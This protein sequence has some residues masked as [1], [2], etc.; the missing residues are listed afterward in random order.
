M[1]ALPEKMGF[2]ISQQQERL[3]RLSREGRAVLRPIRASIR[4]DGFL[5]TERIGPAVAGLVSRHEILR[6]GF[7]MLPGMVLP[8]Q[9][10]GDVEPGAKVWAARSETAAFAAELVAHAPGRHALELRLSPLCA[11]SISLTTLFDELAV[12]YEGGVEVLDGEPL[13]YADYA[14]WQHEVLAADGGEGRRYWFGQGTSDAPSLRLSLEND[15]ENS[16]EVKAVEQYSCSALTPLAPETAAALQEFLSSRQVKAESVLLAAWA[17]LLHH[18]LGAAAFTIGFLCDARAAEIAGAIGPYLRFLPFPVTLGKGETF[19]DLTMR[20]QARM[21]SHREWQ[22]VYPG[23]AHRWEFGFGCSEAAPTRRAGSVTLSL[24]ADHSPP[25]PCRLHLH[26]LIRDCEVLLAFHYDGERLGP[27]AVDCMSGQLLSLLTEAMRDP[28]TAWERLSLLGS[29]EH[30][31]LATCHGG[32]T[33]APDVNAL[34]KLFEAQ[35]L[36][37]PGAAALRHAGVVITYGEL[38]QRSNALARRLIEAGLKAEDRVGLLLPSPLCMV[39]AILAVLKAGGAYVPLD[40]AQPGERTSYVLTDAAARLVVSECGS[41]AAL[42]GFDGTVLSHG[43]QDEAGLSENAA[44]WP[45]PPIQPEQLAYLIYTSGSTGQPKGVAISHG[46]ALRSTLARHRVYHEAV[47]GFLLLSSFSFDSSVAGLFW[48]L[49]QGGCLCLP[50]EAELQ[51]PDALA[52]LIERHT[53]SHVLCLPSVWAVLLE[54][55]AAR[56]RSLRVAI[57]AGE[58]CPPGLGSRHFGSLPDTRL[59]NEYGPTEGAVWSTVQEIEPRGGALRVPIGRPIE[60]VRIH[61]L[62]PAGIEVPRGITGEI[63]IGGGG[64][65]R[66]Y[67]RRPALTGATFVPDF[68]SG[69]GSRLYRSGDLGRWRLD[70]MIDF[71]GRADHQIKVRGYRI[72]LGE[73]EFRIRALPGVRDCAVVAREDEPG[74]KRLTAYLVHFNWPDRQGTQGHGTGLEQVRNALKSSLPDYMIP[75][76]WVVLDELPRNANG[77]LDRSRLPVPDRTGRRRAFVAPRGSVETVL[78]EIWE[79]LLSIRPVGIEDNFFELGGDSILSIQMVGRARQRGIVVTARQMIENQTIAQ[80]ATVAAQLHAANTPDHAPSLASAGEIPLT[81]IQCWFFELGY[82]RPELWTHALLLALREPLPPDVLAEAAAALLR[83]HDALRS[84]FHHD[85][86]VW[87]QTILPAAAEGAVVRVVLPELPEAERHAEIE[88]RAMS[89]MAIGID[90]GR[91][92][93]VIHFEGSAGKPGHLLVVLH[94]LVADGISWRLLIEDLDLSCRQIRQGSDIAL[95]MRS[96]SFAEWS[97]LLKGRVAGSVLVEQAEWWREQLRQA[98][99]PLRPDNTAG[100]RREATSAA[101]TR[102]FDA[103]ET[104]ALLQRAAPAFRAS[105][106]DLLLTALAL[107][108]VRHSG[109]ENGREGKTVLIDLD[110]HGRE[111]FDSELD[112]SRTIGWFTS[113][114]PYLLTVDPAQPLRTSLKCVKEQ[115]RRVPERGLGYGIMRYLAPEGNAASL[116]DGPPSEIIFNYMGQLDPSFGPDSLFSMADEEI[117][118]GRD[119]NWERPYELAVNAD[120]LAGRLRVVWDYGAQR[121][122]RQTIESLA[123]DF[124]ETLRRL[125][126]AC[127]A[128]GVGGYTPSDFPLAALGQEQLDTLL[129]ATADIE[130]VYPITPLQEGM[131]FHSLYAPQSGVYVEHLSCI[132]KGHLDLSAFEAAW[133]QVLRSCPVLRTRFV[134]E[135]L[136]RPLQVVHSAVA[137]P[138]GVQDWRSFPPDEQERRWAEYLEVDWRQGFD[139][140]TAPLMRLALL[141]R[142]EDSWYF[143]WSHH[144]IL[145]DGWSGPL[146]LQQA[147]D[148]YR[149]LSAGDPPPRF[150]RR[151]FR[152][153]IAFL[154]RQERAAPEAFFRRFLAGFGE[155][156]PLPLDCLPARSMAGRGKNGP[157][158]FEKSLA[159]SEEATAALETAARRFKVTINT[160]LQ[161]AFSLL[162]ARYSGRR[163]VLFGISV[164]GR[165]AELPGIEEMVGLFI[166]AMPLRVA[167]PPEAAIGE[168]LRQLLAINAEL[169]QYEWTPLVEIQ[170]WSE[171]PR[172][173]ALFE[174]LFAFENYPVD[175]ALREQQ[176]PLVPGGVRFTEQTHYPLTVVA[177]PGPTLII[178]FNADRSYF[179]EG[180]VAGLV[181]YFANLLAGI[182]AAPEGR[183][184]DLCLLAPGEQRRLIA[185]WYGEGTV[186]AD[187]GSLAALFEAQVTRTPDAAALTCEGVSLSYGV[188]NVRANRLA[189]H[190]RR[191]G[192]RPETRVGLCLDRSLDLFVAILAVVKAGGAYVPLDPAHPKERLAWLIGDAGIAVLL[193]AEAMLGSL[194]DGVAASGPPILCLDRDAAGWAEEAAENLSGPSHPDQ[195]A[196]VIYTS[197]S[198]GRPKGVM[199]TQRNVTRLFAAAAPGFGFGPADVWTLFHSYAFDFSVWEM[200]GALLHGG[201]LVV[202]PYWVSRAPDLSMSCSGASG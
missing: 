35:A 48:T 61:I 104:E 156:T 29:D 73:I 188:L 128:P 64:V 45:A 39:E 60:G 161:G 36:G 112:L 1:N 6:T 123:Q 119:P 202:V 151:P 102:V 180:L 72:E 75:S 94:H 70:G 68:F 126:A 50:Q 98:P 14:A 122:R 78:A 118:S 58:P 170:G 55:E 77:K 142:G 175:A 117:R 23:E 187:Q 51:D 136:D 19:S 100:D 163:D 110:R 181:G 148:C 63:H 153:Y 81:P 105:V 160:L 66:G 24:E 200:W 20:V 31:W 4:I 152:D 157:G 129:G 96:A 88:R 167:L 172:G 99:L 9:V 10:V 69:E 184:G 62:S 71:L 16:S 97:Q 159:L 82:Q 133:A 107:T 106:E 127:V 49:S 12:L 89:F 93:R 13:Q 32:A 147:F 18:H 108:L 199:V 139:F 90:D 26:A 124:Q 134:W 137:L 76:D 34:H 103:T 101:V 91:M 186:F 80:L 83:H 42:P 155:P 198:T 194:P 54:Q 22:D 196:Y 111:P 86:G 179:E 190:L 5:D 125:I 114:A 144:H 158:H 8:I 67:F 15:P 143:L 130:D 178:K 47:T 173:K 59:Y 171:V 192:V 201:R 46:S 195:L 41:A 168:W 52:T 17:I 165:P 3:W 183:L 33:R 189:R 92:L 57:V 182:V 120:I 87:H 30:R 115:I 27:E 109:G 84:R 149:A 166:N 145:L 95:P 162:L 138:V 191:L 85:G 169:R 25:E 132:L 2:S 38:N 7:E 176:G 11:D 65:A 121:W 28:D 197:G 113:V 150:P 174:I 154:S 37:T 177:I 74:E 185:A 135:G 141:R 146:V 40:P 79:E 116:R 53:L 21:S 43:L 44:C 140:A 164:S 131:L 193:T 56:L